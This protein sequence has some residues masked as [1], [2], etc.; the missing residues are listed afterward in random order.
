MQKL[1]LSNIKIGMEVDIDQLS[2]IYDTLIIL[3]SDSYTSNTGTIA[4]I[5]KGHTDESRKIMA[6]GKIIAPI[7]NDSTLLDPNIDYDE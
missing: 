1:A 6:S 5:G 7:Y 3:T 4:F 2:E